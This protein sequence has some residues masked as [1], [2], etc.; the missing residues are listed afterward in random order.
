MDLDAAR[1]LLVR[2]VPL[3]LAARAFGCSPELLAPF[4]KDGAVSLGHAF[5]AARRQAEACLRAV[6]RAHRSA[7][8]VARR[9]AERTARAF[10]PVDRLVLVL[11]AL[12]AAMA[13]SCAALADR[14][15]P[16]APRLADLVARAG[17]AV[18]ETDPA[19]GWR[20]ARRAR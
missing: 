18:I 5:A 8:M 12:R 14:L 4:A 9:A 15:R 1:A 10:T 13:A 3:A 16:L 17:Q 20:I 19:V 11:A 7:L 6:R 2:P